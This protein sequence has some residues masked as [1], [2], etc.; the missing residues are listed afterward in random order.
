MSLQVSATGGCCPCP[1]LVGCAC[2]SICAIECR[3]KE[4]DGALCGFEEFEPS[5]PPRKYRLKEIGADAAKRKMTVCDF[6]ELADCE[7][8]ECPG[9]FEFSSGSLGIAGSPY[10]YRI[11]SSAVL[12]G[13]AGGLA[14]YAIT[15]EAERRLGTDPWEPVGARL[16]FTDGVSVHN[17]TTGETLDLPVGEE[18]GINVQIDYVGYQTVG[19]GCI[20]TGVD[21]PEGYQDHWQKVEV[22]DEDTCELSQPTDIKHRRLNNEACPDEDCDGCGAEGALACVDPPACYGAGADVVTTP[23]TRTTTGVGCLANGD[24]TFTKYTGTIE[25]ELSDEDTEEDA[26]ER[27]VGGEGW[28]TPG[29]D[30]LLHPAFKTLRGAGSFD[31]AFRHVQVRIKLMELAAS[32]SYEVTVRFFRRVLGTTGPYLFYSAEVLTVMTD[33]NPLTD[34]FTP[35]ID[36]PNEAGWETRAQTCSVELLP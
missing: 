6:K 9:S 32:T 17:K 29:D 4:G 16:S 27:A 2:E 24:G 21:D 36:V 3:E 25:E 18:W 22:Y 12:M 30:C 23:T 13:V 26:I 14:T 31:F 33:S 7:P 19:S 15:A 28:V 1:D 34:D 8:A 10:E 11:A 5:V 35:W 20:T